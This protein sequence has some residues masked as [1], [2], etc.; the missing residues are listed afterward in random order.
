MLNF[1]LLNFSLSRHCYWKTWLNSITVKI[2]LIPV[3]LVQPSPFVSFNSTVLYFNVGW[4]VKFNWTKD[5]SLYWKTRLNSITMVKCSETSLV[6]FNHPLPAH[7]FRLNQTCALKPVWLNSTTPCLLI[8]YN[9]KRHNSFCWN[10][11]LN[12]TTPY[13]LINFNWKRHNSFF[14]NTWL[15]STT[16]EN[17]SSTKYAKVK[18]TCTIKTLDTFTEIYGWI[19]P[20]LK[21]A[22]KLM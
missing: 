6:E 21:C 17:M 8:K 2:V 7:E 9:R 10:T 13:L 11:W 16:F 3:Q 14:W 19:Q 22:M 20:L 18:F 15:N 12:S 5:Y 1:I 4:L